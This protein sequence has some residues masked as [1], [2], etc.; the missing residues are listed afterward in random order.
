MLIEGRYGTLYLV[1]I[2]MLV[3][4]FTVCKIFTVACV[5]P[6]P[7]E[8]VKAKCKYVNWKATCAVLCI[9]N[10]IVCPICQRLRDN[11]IWTS[12]CIQFNFF[13]SEIKVAN[14]D[15]LSSFNW[16]LKLELPGPTIYSWHISRRTTDVWT[17]IRPYILPRRITPFNSV[18]TVQ[19]TA[20]LYKPTGVWLCQLYWRLLYWGRRPRTIC[21]GAPIYLCHLKRIFSATDGQRCAVP[22]CASCREFDSQTVPAFVYWITLTETPADTDAATRRCTSRDRAAAT[23]YRAS[24]LPVCD[25]K[26]PHR[27]R[28][29]IKML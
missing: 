9:G 6:W 10:S 29:R 12:H 2:V 3:L 11:R 8:W 24:P 5:W 27:R 21:S 28:N 13:T 20:A 4:P 25:K 1:A 18:E 16:M 19:E 23:T 17:D 14:V 7:L 15:N 26:I 22:K